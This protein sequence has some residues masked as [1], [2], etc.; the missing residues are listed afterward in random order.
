MTPL[1]WALVPFALIGLVTVGLILWVAVT[2][3]V[4]GYFDEGKK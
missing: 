3:D 4:A 1:T 2:E